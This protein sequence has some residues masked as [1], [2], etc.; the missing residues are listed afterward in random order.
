MDKVNELELARMLMREM[1]RRR[2]RKSASKAF[3]LSEDALKAIEKMD[4]AMFAEG[5]YP[6]PFKGLK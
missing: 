1:T 3:G 6:D 5:E 4:G 2:S